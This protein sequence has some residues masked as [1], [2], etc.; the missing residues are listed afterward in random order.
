MSL[1]LIKNYAMKTYGGGKYS[2]TVLD[3]SAR[4]RSVINFMPLPLYP[5]GKSPWYQL[6]RRLSGP[7]SL[8]AVKE[9]KN[10]P[11]AHCYID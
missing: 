9:I 8:D 7:Q 6:D 11:K 1:C 2:S 3:L 5:W 10:G 4:W